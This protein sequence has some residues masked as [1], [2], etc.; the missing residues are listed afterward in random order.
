VFNEPLLLYSATKAL[1]YCNIYFYVLYIYVHFLTKL[2]LLVDAEH[3]MVAF[4]VERKLTLTKMYLCQCATEVPTNQD[5]I[6]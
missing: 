4:F 1:K 6:L 2:A 3:T 5:I